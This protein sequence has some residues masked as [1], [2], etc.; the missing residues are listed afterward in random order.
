MHPDVLPYLRCPVCGDRLSSGAATAAGRSVRCGRGHAFDLARQGYLNLAT[1]R[2]RHSGDT[3]AMV[4]ARAE[5]LAAGHYRFIAEALA[6]AAAARRAGPGLVVD[7]GAGTG[8]HLGS[9]LDA[10]PGAVGLA[11]DSSKAA[12]RRAGRAHP[13]ATAV[14]CDV[15]RRL[16]IADSCAQLVLNVFAPRNPAEFRRVL[17]PD[18]DLLV[19]TPEPEHLTELVEALGLLRVDPAKADRLSHDL[20]APV[21]ERRLTR[22]LPL[23]HRVLRDLVAMGPS[24]WHTDPTAVAAL[25]EP[26]PVTAAVRLRRYRPVS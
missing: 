24:A 13:R 18:G 15:W 9:V 12:A 7:V 6:A 11:L 21:E 25:P 26:F 14:V 2:L 8:Y 19:V 20:G 5:F 23:G 22:T 10:R 16:P 3:A 4:A 1:G 17:A